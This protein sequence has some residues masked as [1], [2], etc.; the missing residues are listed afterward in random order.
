MSNKK[1]FVIFDIIDGV[2]H[3]LRETDEFKFIGKFNQ[4]M[5]FWYIVSNFQFVQFTSQVLIYF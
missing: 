4:L 3:A 2:I 1:L 5:I